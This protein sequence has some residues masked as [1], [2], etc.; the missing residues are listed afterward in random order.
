MRYLRKFNE[1]VD[2]VMENLHGLV[3]DFIKRK[4]LYNEDKEI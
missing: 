3:I 2:N 4:R 1:S